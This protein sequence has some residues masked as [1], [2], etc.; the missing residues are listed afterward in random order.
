MTKTK[1]ML[2]GGRTYGVYNPAT[3]KFWCTHGAW[4]GDIKIIDDNTCILFK[5]VVTY[6]FIDKIP[7]DYNYT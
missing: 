5:E 6:E 2:L 3:K 7:E 1:N 4:E